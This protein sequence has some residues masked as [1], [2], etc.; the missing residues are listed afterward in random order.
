L[1]ARICRRRPYRIWILIIER[2]VVLHRLRLIRQM[3]PRGTVLL[4]PAVTANTADPA[5]RNLLLLSFTRFSSLVI[6]HGPLSS[7]KTTVIKT[8][9]SVID[10]LKATAFKTTLQQHHKWPI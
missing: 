5:S 9:G 6:A 7:H 1:S 3:V 10:C 8:L 4:F 2:G